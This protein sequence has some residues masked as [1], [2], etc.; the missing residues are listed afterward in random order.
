MGLGDF[1]LLLV[2]ETSATVLSL[3]S[4]VMLLLAYSLDKVAVSVML[5]LGAIVALD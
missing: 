4:Q 2:L 1:F 5:S 3:D